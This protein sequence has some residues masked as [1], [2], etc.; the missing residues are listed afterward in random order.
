MKHAWICDDALF[1]STGVKCEFCVCPHQSLSYSEFGII[2]E[3]I[4]C[5]NILVCLFFLTCYAFLRAIETC[6][7]MTGH[8]ESHA[9]V[10]FALRQGCYGHLK[11]QRR[12]LKVSPLLN[13]K[14]T[15]LWN[16]SSMSHFFSPPLKVI[17]QEFCHS[18]IWVPYQSHL[19]I[20]FQV[21]F[22]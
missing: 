9:A 21:W 2:Y 10:L 22:K 1:E 20:S 17:L 5:I 6:F 7:Y 8:L 15:H 12:G 4:S 18:C 11:P 19:L 16:L 13:S 3:S 14:A